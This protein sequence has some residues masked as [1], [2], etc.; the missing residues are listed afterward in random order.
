[1]IYFEYKLRS[2]GWARATIS[3]KEHQVSIRASYLC[4]ALRDFTDAVQR[5]FVR[6]MAEC[7]WEQE[8][9]L[10]VWEFRRTDSVLTVKAQW[11]HEE[12]AS[13]VG[14]DD[15]VHFSSEVDK[16]LD[17]LLSEWGEERYAKHWGYPF[18]KEAHTA[19]KQA[20]K[21]ERQRRESQGGDSHD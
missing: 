10:V 5:I 6:D 2:H 18:P 19:L 21:L 1:M 11:D 17:A 15:L 3:S 9:E 20:I 7:S 13:F 14:D 16:E 8:P 4:D 12:K